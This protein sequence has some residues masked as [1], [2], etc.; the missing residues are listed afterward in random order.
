MDIAADSRTY[1]RAATTVDYP[2][3]ERLSVHSPDATA[4]R[5]AFRPSWTPLSR[6]AGAPREGHRGEPLPRQMLRQSGGFSTGDD[7]T[8]FSP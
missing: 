2:L 1:G 5:I 3:R 6:I 4:S 7:L 8:G